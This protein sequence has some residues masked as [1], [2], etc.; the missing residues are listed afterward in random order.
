MDEP[1]ETPVEV[2]AEETP[3]V[4]LTEEQTDAL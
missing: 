1:E 3:D 4:P 2:P